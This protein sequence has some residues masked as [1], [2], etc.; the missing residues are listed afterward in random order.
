MYLF[1]YKSVPDRDLMVRIY[2]GTHPT[3]WHILWYNTDILSQYHMLRY[4]HLQQKTYISNKNIYTNSFTMF[5]NQTDIQF[6]NHKTNLY[7]L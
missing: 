7:G 6:F 3:W 1:A 2:Y 5:Y 4:V